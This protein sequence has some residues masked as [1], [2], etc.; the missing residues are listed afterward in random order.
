MGDRKRMQPN[1][2][3][4]RGE[5]KRERSKLSSTVTCNAR[6]F[7]QW[8]LQNEQQGAQLLRVCK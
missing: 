2:N 5:T 3:L 8:I 4:Y 6:H 1:H 7:F